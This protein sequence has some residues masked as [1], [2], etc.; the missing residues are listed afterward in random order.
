MISKK[1]MTPLKFPSGIVTFLFTD[2]EDSTRLW[3]EFPFEMK[4]ALARHDAILTSHVKDGNGLIVKTTGDGLHAVFS[5]PIDAIG[6]VVAA[7]LALRSENWGEIGPMR[8]R[9]ALHSGEAEQRGGDY[10]GSVVNRA[11]RIMGTA[12][13]EQILISAST[14]DLAAGHLPEEL[15]FLDLGQHYLRG[16]HQP[17]QL[18]QVLHPDLPAEFPTLKTLG[19][20][21]NNLPAE[22]TSFIG[23]KNELA[24]L[25]QLLSPNGANHRLVT[26]TGPGGTGK[27]R[28]ALKS[29]RDVLDQ[30][31]QGVWLAELAP[32]TEPQ[33]VIQ[34][35]ASPMGVRDQGA[36]PLELMVADHLRSQ[37]TLLI[38]DNCEHL[39]DECARLAELLLKTC[40]KLHILASSRESF[41]IVGEQPFRVRS[42]SLPPA[43][44]NINV[45]EMVQY[46]AVRLFTERGIEV[47]PGFS[48]DANNAKDISQICHRLDG[49][50][51]AIELA[52]ARVRVLSPKQIADRLDDR[53]RL[54]T[55]GSRTALPRQRTLQAL[56]DW[57]YDLLP[58]EES[59]LLCRLSVFINGWTLEAAEAVTG[60]KPLEAYQVLDL[61]EQL[62]NKSLVMTEETELGMRYSMLESIRQYA[63]EKLA[64][65][66]ESN[67]L[68]DRHLSFFLKES[69]DAHQRLMDLQPPGDWGKRF[70]PEADNF[71][72]AWTWAIEEDLEKAILFTSSFSSGWSQVAP[73]VEVSQYQQ[74]VLALAEIHPL[75]MNSDARVENRILLAR[76][77]ISAA[78]VASGTRNLRL[79]V[80]IA[81]RSA[82]LAEEVGDLA[83]LA[84]ANTIVK[85]GASFT[86]GK[87]SI[88]TWLDEGYDLV[89]QFGHNF[90]KAICLA[91]W[92]SA[93]FFVTGQYT[94]ESQEKWDKGMAMLV[95]SG[96]LWSQG[97]LLQVAADI[98]LF[99]GEA[100]QAKFMAEQVLEIYSELGDDYA[101]NPARSL[102]ADLARQ[103]GDLV[104]AT[105]LYRETIIG[106]RDSG[107]AEAGV[108]TMESLAYIMHALAH[109]EDGVNLPARL[110]YAAKLLG[111][112]DAI[113]KRINRPVNFVDK[114]EYERELVEIQE[115]AATAVFEIAWEEGQSLDLDEAVLLAIEDPFPPIDA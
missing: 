43:D 97:S 96:D 41:G 78:H 32:V 66:D 5:S 77:L 69:M 48:L 50:P 52:A 75:Y 72:T 62:V 20:T 25:D 49:I 59:A 7:Q 61:L 23:R 86:G 53:F 19:T 47:K 14:A 39:I 102:L 37:Q 100:D 9:M 57:S 56:I 35:V 74:S 73:I 15:T 13:G 71:R 26:L 46:E 8:V 85:M 21:P 113:R 105:L 12:A 101:A 65:S 99:L 70:K 64:D 108:R 109:E 17:E 36:R 51:L 3:E 29:A 6:V 67:E 22:V 18:Y 31:P 1:K 107:R 11:A 60:F 83:T 112:A 103:R 33:Q 34:A 115:E 106:W 4:A 30:Y 82:V 27:T 63:Q 104:K 84:F 2:L 92:G 91:W 81:S 87:E 79:G 80:E 114:T 111:A 68:H 88:Q 16:L 54:L 28:L 89:M 44:N 38:L 94:Q 24:E 40:P 58:E 55:G 93:N 95:R 10:Y 76:A 90:H 45:N 42:L 98:K 110:T